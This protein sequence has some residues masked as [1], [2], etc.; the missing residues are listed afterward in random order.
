VKKETRRQAAL[1]AWPQ[2]TELRTAVRCKRGVV[3]G[4]RMLVAVGITVLASAGNNIG[5]A[6]QKSGTQ[7]L[8]RFEL[9][10]K[11]LRQYARCR[12]YMAGM[13][14]DV[15][16]ALLMI[17]A[18]AQAPVHSPP[19]HSLPHLAPYPALEQCLQDLV[20]P[21]AYCCWRTLPA[22]LFPRCCACY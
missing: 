15:G 7:N 20:T 3:G 8:P 11:V 22:R 9:D 5:K 2:R 6:L 12:T 18:F 10:G 4:N 19:S 21:R 1:V 17:A 13:A 14:M 16:G